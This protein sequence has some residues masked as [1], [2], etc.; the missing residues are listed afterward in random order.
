MLRTLHHSQA[1]LP[2]VQIPF[3]PQSILQYY[4]QTNLF[5][6]LIPIATSF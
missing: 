2:K 3:T 6:S 5:P 1:Q 4:F